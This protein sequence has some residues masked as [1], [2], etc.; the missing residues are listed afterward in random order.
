MPIEGAAL[1]HLL[2]FIHHSDQTDKM[3]VDG[4]GV[5]APLDV[6][7]FISDCEMTT[8]HDLVRGFRRLLNHPE[9]GAGNKLTLKEVT[10]RVGSVKT[11][12]GVKFIQLQ[13]RFRGMR[14]EDIALA[15]E[16]IDVRE[17]EEE[18][19]LRRDN[20]FRRKAIYKPSKQTESDNFIM[21][22][23]K[24]EL[25]PPPPPPPGTFI[26]ISR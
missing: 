21:P 9:C 1:H 16:G 3:S 22:K 2:Q 15:I 5:L 24:E 14:A 12:E 7:A 23:A 10:R 8:N 11:V 18:A 19:A 25:L 20:T 17:G 6:I 13:A 26:F 4:S